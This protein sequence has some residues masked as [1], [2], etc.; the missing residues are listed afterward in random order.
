MIFAG[1]LHFLSNRRGLIAVSFQTILAA[2]DSTQGGTY[3][4]EN[5][6]TPRIEIEAPQPKRLPTCIHTPHSASTVPVPYLYLN[7]VF[8]PII[9]A[10]K[11]S[12]VRLA[13]HMEDGASGKRDSTPG[14]ACSL[15]RLAV[16][17]QR[18]SSH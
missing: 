17:L 2:P 3:P 14:R 10:P 1:Y 8:F 9:M 11:P 6:T 15:F 18:N 5:H 12:A 16:S 13:S 7:A 4:H